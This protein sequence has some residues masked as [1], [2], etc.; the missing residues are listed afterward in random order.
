MILDVKLSLLVFI[1]IF[2]RF[3][4]IFLFFLQHNLPA[5]LEAQLRYRMMNRIKAQLLEFLKV[6][7]SSY[8]CL[9]RRRCICVNPLLLSSLMT[10]LF[11]YH[12]CLI[13]PLLDPFF[14][15]Y[16]SIILPFLVPTSPPYV[17]LIHALIIPHSILSHPLLTLFLHL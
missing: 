2:A 8:N 7:Y 5:Y 17:S 12:L 16:S 13:H 14:I 1:H 6:T 10:S 3:D 4:C 15:S 9:H 11:H